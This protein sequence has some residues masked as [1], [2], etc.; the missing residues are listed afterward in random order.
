MWDRDFPWGET[1]QCVDQGLNCFSRNHRHVDLGEALDSDERSVA[2]RG[3]TSSDH[4]LVSRHCP[5]PG[6]SDVLGGQIIRCKS[7]LI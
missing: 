6:K 3:S 7:G 1:F 5:V 2:S 4:F